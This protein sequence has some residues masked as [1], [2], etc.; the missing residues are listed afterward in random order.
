MSVLFPTDVV[1]LLCVDVSVDVSGTAALHTWA[2][3]PVPKAL[4][5]IHPCSLLLPI[6]LCSGCSDSLSNCFTI[7]NCGM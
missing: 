6:H 3:H 2:L 1:P 7:R 4:L 5:R